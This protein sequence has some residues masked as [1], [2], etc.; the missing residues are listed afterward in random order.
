MAFL[1]MSFKSISNSESFT[2][3]GIPHCIP[4]FASKV[5]PAVKSSID[6]F[7]LN[8]N[9]I[10]SPRRPLGWFTK[11]PACSSRQTL[12]MLLQLFA[13]IISGLLPALLTTFTSAPA[14]NNR[15]TDRASACNEA[16]GGSCTAEVE[17]EFST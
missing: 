12:S 14:R 5:S 1:Q 8:D 11:A 16:L 10:L 3:P 6:S 9:W 2:Y 17:F 4:I 7:L 15:T 13:A